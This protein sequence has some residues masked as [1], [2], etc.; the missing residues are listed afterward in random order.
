VG[1]MPSIQTV[2]EQESARP[3]GAILLTVNVVDWIPAV[4]SFMNENGYT[5]PALVDLDSETAI[6]YGVSNIPHTVFVDRRGVIKAIKIGAFG[7]S[8]DIRAYLNRITR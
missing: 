2:Y 7:G 8:G 4:K 5:M 1:E 3:E 6:A